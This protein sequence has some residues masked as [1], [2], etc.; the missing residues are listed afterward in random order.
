MFVLSPGDALLRPQLL[1]MLPFTLNRLTISLQPSLEK[2]ESQ[3]LQLINA[4]C[5]NTV[6]PC[7]HNMHNHDSS[8]IWHIRAV[9]V[10][11]MR[12]GQRCLTMFWSL[13]SYSGLRVWVNVWIACVPKIDF[14]LRKEWQVYTHIKQICFFY[15]FISHPSF[16]CT[17]Y[18]AYRGK[19]KSLYS[20]YK[21]TYTVLITCHPCGE[22]VHY[23]SQIKDSRDGL[24][25]PLP[26]LFSVAWCFLLSHFT[27]LLHTST[28]PFTAA[29]AI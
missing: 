7:I 17:V 3:L 16:K 26:R 2:F 19:N 8:C 22:T 11:I 18:G 6:R 25:K 10:Y 15:H 23:A 20:W 12:G 29:T 27:F 9:I 13:F 14:L 24:D 21:G 1:K 4:D 5:H 28:S